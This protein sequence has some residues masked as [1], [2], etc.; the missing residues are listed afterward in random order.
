MLKASVQGQLTANQLD[1]CYTPIV[2]SGDQCALKLS[3]ESPA[4]PIHFGA[5]I[6][7]MGVRVQNYCSNVARTLMVQ[8][9]SLVEELYELCLT[10]QAAIVNA[11]KP[12]NTIASA[13]EAG[14]NHFKEAK[15]DYLPY[16]VKNGFG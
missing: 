15:P 13:Y 3:A 2:Q 10:T 9:T 8:P 1:V 11:L 4:K 12:G 14:I 5:I 6:S 7:M 16:L